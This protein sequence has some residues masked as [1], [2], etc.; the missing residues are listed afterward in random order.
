MQFVEVQF[1]FSDLG[2]AGNRF[3]NADHRTGFVDNLA[4]VLVQVVPIDT[5]EE[6]LIFPFFEIVHVEDVARPAIPLAS[7]GA[8]LLRLRQ[9]EKL[10]LPRS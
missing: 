10:A 5:L 2:F 8:G 1:A 7:E 9:V 3:H 6:W 4:A